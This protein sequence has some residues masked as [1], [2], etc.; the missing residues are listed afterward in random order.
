VAVRAV[1][2][3]T[4]PSAEALDA[5]LRAAKTPVVGRISNDHLLLDVRTLGDREL[6]DV[7]RAFEAKLD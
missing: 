6:P 1:D 5:R 7:A 2:P 4:G 3:A